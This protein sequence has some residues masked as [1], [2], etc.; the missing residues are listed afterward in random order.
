[1]VY[2]QNYIGQNGMDRMVWTK[3]YEKNGSIFYIDFNLIE[4]SFY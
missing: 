2:G 1:M 3:W 4:F